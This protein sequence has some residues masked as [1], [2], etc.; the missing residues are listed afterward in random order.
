M[1]IVPV[2]D[3]K[4]GLVVYAQRGNRSHYQPIHLYSALTGS[5]DIDAVMTGFLNLHPFKQ[6]YIADLNA[7]IGSGHHRPLIESMLTAYPDIEFWIDSGSQLS[8]ISAGWPNQKCV[9]G[10]ESQQNSACQSG[11]AYILSLDYKNQ[12]PAGHNSWFEQSQFWPDKIIVMTLSRVG[13]NSGPDLEK[14]TEFCRRHPA[15]QFIAAGGIRHA[16]D[17]E[18]LKNLG[19]HAALLA[20]ALHNGTIGS[21]QIKNL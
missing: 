19:I 16:A 6:F 12:Q 7:I 3:L 21:A 9:I 5:S 11:Q 18:N 4:D 8:Q 2:I 10:T 20:T 15:K 13:S 1:H 14:L 17:L